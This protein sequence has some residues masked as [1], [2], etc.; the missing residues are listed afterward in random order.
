MD[1]Q[2]EYT[3]ELVDYFPKKAM[4]RNMAPKTIETTNYQELIN[5][6]QDDTKSR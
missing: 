4:S 3:E 5:H 6:Y 1:I 2:L